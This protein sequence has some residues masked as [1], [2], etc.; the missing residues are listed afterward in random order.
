MSS[1]LRCACADSSGTTKRRERGSGTSRGSRARVP[2]NVV[3]LITD[4][5]HELPPACLDLLDTASCM[6][7]EFDLRTLASVHSMS[8]SAVA[9][10]LGAA[11]RAGVIVPLDTRYKDFQ[12]LDGWDLSPGAPRDPE[13]RAIASSTTRCGRRCMNGL[14]RRSRPSAI[15]ASAAC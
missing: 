15:C 12:S 1:C 2:D 4:R 7:G 3:A 14:T 5:L 8:P 11:V 9:V 13:R 10:G 6:G